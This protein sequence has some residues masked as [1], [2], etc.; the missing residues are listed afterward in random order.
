MDLFDILLIIHILA[1]MIWIGG[2]LVGMLI[3]IFLSKGDD[4]TAMSKFC[5]AFATI[6]G[7]PPSSAA[8]LM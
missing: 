6:A 7:K 8:S 1:A 2:A 5:T 3:G 4:A